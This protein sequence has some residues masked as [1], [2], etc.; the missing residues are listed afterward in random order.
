ME[1][2]T[3]SKAVRAGDLVNGTALDPARRFAFEVPCRALEIDD[4]TLK[5]A[6]HSWAVR[7]RKRGGSLEAIAEQLGHNR[8]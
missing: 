2:R 7:C 1:P 6:R 5:G 8:F 3:Q 4:Y